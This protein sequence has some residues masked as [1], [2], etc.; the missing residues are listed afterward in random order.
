AYPQGTLGVSDDA[1]A[2]KDKFGWSVFKLN[3]YIDTFKGA[4]ELDRKHV[5]FGTSIGLMVLSVYVILESIR[6][7]TEFNARIATVL[8]QSPGF[9]PLVLGSAL[10]FCS[11]LLLARS[12]KG[13][14]VSEHL[15]KIKSG[16]AAFATSSTTHKSIVGCAWMGVYIFVLLPQLGFL[17]G[18]VL[19]L[20]VFITLLQV[21]TFSGAGV[22]VAVLTVL[23]TLVISVLVVGAI[24]SLF[25]L[26]FRVPLP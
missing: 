1:I 20:F 24:F 13:A 12:L 15:A 10:L 14:T 5:D 17:V 25:Q 19:F 18:T 8:H 21:G 9:F 6:F 11:I 7:H 22:K 2:Q 4:I 3:G 26:F 16:A 23:T